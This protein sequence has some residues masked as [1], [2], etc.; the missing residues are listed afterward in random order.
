MHLEILG[1][2]IFS[3]MIT[4]SESI[5]DWISFSYEFNQPQTPSPSPFSGTINQFNCGNAFL[6]TAKGTMMKFFNFFFHIEVICFVLFSYYIFLYHGGATWSV[7]T[8]CG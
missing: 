7:T 6:S 2:R 1:R 5:H 8:Q 3:C 4:L